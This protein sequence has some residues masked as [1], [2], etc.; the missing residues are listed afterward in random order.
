MNQNVQD[1]KIKRC[2]HCNTTSNLRTNKNGVIYNCCIKCYKEIEVPSQIEKTNQA[3]IKKYGAAGLGALRSKR[4]KESL[5]VEKPKVK[6]TCL[7]CGS[8]DVIISKN[9]RITFPCCKDHW[10]LHQI[11]LDSKRKSTNLEKYGNESLMQ[12]SE[13]REKLKSTIQ[14]RY[15]CDYPMQNRGII[16]KR[17]LHNLEKFGSAGPM[18]NKEVQEKAKKTVLEH[19]GVDSVMKSPEVVKN[20]KKSFLKKYGVDNPQKCKE[21]KEKTK[22][23]N[24]RKYGVEYPSQC[25]EIVA[26]RSSN[27]RFKYWDTFIKLLELKQLEPLFT[28]E[29]YKKG[30]ATFKFRCLRCNRIFISDKT[31]IQGIGC[32]CYQYRSRYEDQI[33]DW[34]KSI[35]VINIETNKR[36]GRKGKSSYY[37]IDL[38][39]T[40]FNIGIDFHGLF[41]HSEQVQSAK[42]HQDK[43]LFFKDL[44]ISYIQIFE[45]EWLIKTDIVKSII[46]SKLQKS[47]VIFARNCEIKN[48]SNSEYSDFLQI[49]H[50]QGYVPAS[51]KLG[52]FYESNLVCLASFGK[53]RYDKKNNA[54]ELLRFCTRLEYSVVGGFQKL[55]KDFE[56]NC[57]PEILL[58]YINVRYF[59][60]SGYLKAGFNLDTLTSPNYFY[61]HLSDVK[62]IFS[63]EKFQ[64]HKLEKLL[65]IYDKNLSES[66]NMFRNRYLRV[67]DAGNLKVVKKYN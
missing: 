37:E 13:K 8:E 30:G 42:Y 50:L 41:W 5:K 39:L 23:T 34:L 2:K 11:I 47:K 45:N 22:E 52:L 64:K 28:Q 44:G 55:L 49:N 17:S 54:F 14:E 63:R 48:L 15:G 60:G 26:K 35:G 66:E 16:N 9:N 59:D 62:T 40:D 19:Y 61:F 25:E 21:I 36:F 56:T 65:P 67:F 43:Y 31:Y 20:L 18:G 10:E 3:M 46:I 4:S 24:I 51:I 12:I 38:Y 53:S 57:K 6:K 1:S 32:S 29:D 7:Y 27:N 58:S 33:L